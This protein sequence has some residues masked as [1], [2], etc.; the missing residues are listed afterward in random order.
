MVYSLSTL[1]I[2]L[3]DAR[4]DFIPFRIKRILVLYTT[5]KK[6]HV[7]QIVLIKLLGRNV[8]LFDIT[9]SLAINSHIGNI[10][11]VR[12][13]SH[14]CYSIIIIFYIYFIKLN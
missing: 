4:K 10:K 13:V 1:A 5:K 3:S 11:F 6:R 7:T 2:V 12:Y 9:I 8:K 14:V